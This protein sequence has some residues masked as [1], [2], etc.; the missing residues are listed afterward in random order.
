M[1]SVEVDLPNDQKLHFL[2][3]VKGQ[4]T[5]FG[6]NRYRCRLVE[7]AENLEFITQK[8]RTR[9][10]PSLGFPLVEMGDAGVWIMVL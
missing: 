5:V 2:V 8:N 3:Y 7:Y 9:S 6:L 1:V 10:I 4:L